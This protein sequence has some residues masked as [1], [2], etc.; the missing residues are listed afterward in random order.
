[1]KGFLIVYQACA[2]L[3]IFG[4]HTASVAETNRPNG[5]VE[6]CFEDI[7]PAAMG[8]S[9]S[10]GALPGY[11]LNLFRKIVH[12]GVARA[13]WSSEW[14]WVTESSLCVVTVGRMHQIVRGVEPTARCVCI[15]SR[16]ICATG[17]AAKL[18]WRLIMLLFVDQCVW[19]T[20][21]I[22]YIFTR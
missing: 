19:L 4:L 15:V 16:A 12:N 9:S 3:H 8:A 14:M 20:L 17:I 11:A 18:P 6:R 21:N 7:L 1:M 5:G 22:S 10:T 13:A 2:M